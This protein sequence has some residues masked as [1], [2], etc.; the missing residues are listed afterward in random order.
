[1]DSVGRLPPIQEAGAGPQGASGAWFS[2]EMHGGR[3]DPSTAQGGGGGRG[4]GGRQ[5]GRG[6]GLGRAPSPTLRSWG[7]F[8]ETA[9][10]H[11]Q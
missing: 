4:K 6:A 2:K 10:G 9:P 7:R 3:H 5:A 11:S 8:K 1:M